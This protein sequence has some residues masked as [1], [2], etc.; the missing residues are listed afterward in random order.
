ML[1]LSTVDDDSIDKCC[2]Y[3]VLSK[4]FCRESFYCESFYS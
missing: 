3:D 2:V 1:H 4:M